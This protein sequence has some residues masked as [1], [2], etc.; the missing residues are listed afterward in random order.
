[1]IAWSLRPA[2]RLVERATPDD[3]IILEEIHAA[4]FHF[5]WAADEL[6]AL[7]AQPGVM[8][9]VARRA[10]RWGSA[11]P[12]GFVTSRTA[13]DEAEL[14]TVAVHPRYRRSGVARELVGTLLRQLYTERIRKVFLEVNPD[15]EAAIGLYRSFGFT[16]AGNRA[17]Y[18]RDNT[19]GAARALIMRLDL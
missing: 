13:A 5:G 1:M 9:L 11:R 10:G 7:E 15:N 16:A 4:S 19:G 12:V 14:L 2:P 8:T 17:N 6:A 3:M 18:Y